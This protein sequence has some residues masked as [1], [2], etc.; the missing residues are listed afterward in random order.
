MYDV[1]RQNKIIEILQQKK[2]IS[3][4]ALTKMLFISP[5]TARR[6]LSALEKKGVIKRTFGGAVLVDP[7][8]AEG[9]IIMRQSMMVKSK[10][11]MCE[12][13]T[14]LLR[15]GNSLFLDSSSTVSNIVPFLQDFR[16]LLIVTNGINV[17]AQLSKSSNFRIILVGGEIAT[18]S[19]S[20]VGPTAV[21]AIDAFHCDILISSCAG[22]DVAT[23]VTEFALE[24]SEIKRI[25]MSH[26]SVRILLAD[27]SKFG[28][29]FF[30]K[31]CPING[32][33]I[34]ITDQKPSQEYIDYCEQ[35]DVRL[36]Y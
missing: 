20:T 27:C 9:S 11:I 31:T 1:E 3:V 25:M 24:Q 23:G 2:S 33:D 13:A 15:N 36:I 22:I 32:F 5:A 8:S 4:N 29:T 17:S 35:N 6:D 10:R 28:K 30:S 12:K 19:N 16:Y 14:S 18:R 21:K 34:L 7:N 26:S